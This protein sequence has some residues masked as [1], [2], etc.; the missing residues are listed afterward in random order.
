MLYDFQ[1]TV[2]N[3]TFQAYQEGAIV[4][5]PVMPTGGGKTVLFCD[6]LTKFDCPSIVI[7]HRQEL[8]SQAALSLNRERVPHSIIAPKAVVQQIIALEHDL[9]GHSTYNSR[10]RT[11]VAGVDTLRNYDTNDRW[12]SQV[13]YGVIDEGHHVLRENKWGREVGKF[14]NARWLFPTAHALRADGKGLGREGGEGFVDRLVVGP[15][16]RQLINR[17]FL[18]DYRLVCV[19]SD[20]ALADVPIGPSG[21]YNM[22]KLRAATHADNHIVGDVVKTY[23]QYAAGKLGVTFAV[24]KEEA[25]KLRN[26]YVAAG[27]PA[28][29][30]TDE[31]PITIRGQLMRKFKA[32]QILQLV[33]VDCLGEG[34]DVPAI[35]VVSLVRRTA[36]WQLLCQQVGRALRV[37]VDDQYARYWPQYSDVERLALI[38]NSNKPKAIIIDHV[39]NIIWHAKFRGLFDS[40]QE[41]SLLSGERNSRKSDAIPLRTCLNCK[42]PYEAYL[43]KCRYCGTEPEPAGRSTPELVQGDLIELDPDVLRALRGETEKI[44]GPYV[45]P[46]GMPGYIVKAQLRHH[47]D[48]FRGQTTL[49]HTMMLWGGYQKH[50]GLNERESQKLFFIRYGIDYLS[51]QALPLTPATELE[52]RIAA[53]LQR[54]NVQEV[55]A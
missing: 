24:D 32:R 21:E 26:A 16:G 44:M 38:A 30:I 4:V 15:Y 22:P 19:G 23:L 41:Y 10:A 34:V 51:A 54:Y 45:A 12:F 48:R 53:D 52:A 17:G 37:M 29:V 9:Q 7:A 39:G 36:S 40:R 2:Q 31:T 33:S 27:V 13:G 49:R 14:P 3:T 47:H 1:S 50:L 5:M 35:E 20:I 42:Q 25:V 18:T 46:Q 28:E 55:Q 43:V 11:R 8:V 6:T